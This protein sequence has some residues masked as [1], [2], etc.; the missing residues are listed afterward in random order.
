MATD[1]PDRDNVEPTPTRENP[2]VPLDTAPPADDRRSGRWFR[3]FL[4][5]I[6]T[7]GLVIAAVLGLK[8]VDLWP[9]FK[10]PFATEKTDRSGPVL[11]KSIQDLSRYVAAEGSFQVLID[12]QENNKYVPDFIFNDRTLFVGAGTVNAYVDFSTL[13]EGAIKESA[14]GKSIEITLPAPQL[15][16]PNLDHDRSYVYDE[17][18]GLINRV[19]DLFGGDPNRQQQVYQLAED[20]IAQAARESE[21]Q[22]RAQRN[23]E[24]MLTSM[25]KSLGYENV[26]VTFASP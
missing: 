21:L 9:D 24:Q 16:K 4:A 26:K 23:T 20:K 8:M 13:G 22:A 15:E 12:L 5:L 2:T 7:V 6:G 19:G 3:R 11:L 18:R 25:L 17:D 1:Q 14:D 10:N